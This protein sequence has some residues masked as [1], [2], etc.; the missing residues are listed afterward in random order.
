MGPVA[1]SLFEFIQE[2][3]LSNHFYINNIFL[4]TD[5]LANHNDHTELLIKGENEQYDAELCS[6]HEKKMKPIEINI[7]N[8]Y[9]LTF[10]PKTKD[11]GEITRFGL[12][13]LKEIITGELNVLTAWLPKRLS[14]PEV[15]AELFATN[16]VSRDWKYF[17]I[18]ENRKYLPSL[19]K[20]L[21]P[22]Q[23][24]LF[25]MLQIP[26]RE[27]QTYSEMPIEWVR[28]MGVNVG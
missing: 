2:N 7:D 19:D 8:P 10:S 17:P 6:I 20:G 9:V 3:K 25:A 16:F 28:A 26:Q 13:K 18:S 21:T 12:P 23:I 15:V 11:A 14:R 5:W 4:G 1:Y 22:Q 27:I 24:V